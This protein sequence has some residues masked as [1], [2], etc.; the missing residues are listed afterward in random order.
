MFRFTIDRGTG[1]EIIKSSIY[2]LTKFINNGRSTGEAVN[3]NG[4]SFG[5]FAV[6]VGLF[7]GYDL[8]LALLEA[9]SAGDVVL[10]SLEEGIV[11]NWG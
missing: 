11:V 1:I 8:E 5:K 3:V 4:S 6:K 9:C 2:Q 7:I 10:F